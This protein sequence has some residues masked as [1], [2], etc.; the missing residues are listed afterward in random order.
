MT[1]EQVVNVLFL[2]VGVLLLAEL[3]I[4]IT[5]DLV[6][7]G[8]R[9]KAEKQFEAIVTDMISKAKESYEK[10]TADDI[11]VEVNGEEV[12]KYCY[13]ADIVDDIDDRIS[14]LE[15]YIA[16]AQEKAAARNKGG[17]PKKS[18]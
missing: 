9:R 13:L 15:A 8:K 2:I 3:S 14:K 10:A 16:E 4:R 11:K 5:R 17:R 6:L 7:S 1:L 18:K 12:D